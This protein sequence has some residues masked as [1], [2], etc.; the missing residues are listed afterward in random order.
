M[1]PTITKECGQFLEE[2]RRKALIKMLPTEGIG[3]RRVKV[4]KKDWDSSFI[5]SF[6]NA[7]ND[8][9][10]LM[11]RCV[12]AS[13]EPEEI[14]G[15]EPFYIFPVDGYQY[16]YSPAVESA[17][18]HYEGLFHKI[19]DCVKEHSVDLFMDILQSE[20][21]SDNIEIALEHNYEIILYDIPYYYAVRK[22]IVDDYKT[23]IYDI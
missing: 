12:L 22:S 19:S 1:I 18:N 13:S 14:V 21:V 5:S 10:N 15:R 23:L 17:K 8:Y 4:R 6:N 2:S 9:K 7:F 11:Q 3:F 16:L 20:Y